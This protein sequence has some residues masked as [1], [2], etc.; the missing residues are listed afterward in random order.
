MNRQG[1]RL[2]E[3]EALR[4]IPFNRR[5]LSLKQRYI[6]D[7]PP[8]RVATV[9]PNPLLT[10]NDATVTG[11]Y[12][13]R[14]YVLDPSPSSLDHAFYLRNTTGSSSLPMY[15][16]SHRLQSLP[17]AENEESREAA[18]ILQNHRWFSILFGGVLSFAG[19]MCLGEWETQR[20]RKQKEMELQK[21][22]L[23]GIGEDR[24]Y[25]MLTQSERSVVA[26]ATVTKP[27][28]LTNKRKKEKKSMAE[29]FRPF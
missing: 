17:I 26:A 29:W 28:C 11:S 12:L 14:S 6:L 19:L 1:F 3:R 2:F 7:P 20:T 5:Y 8:T 27:S 24:Q 15:A 25:V 16:L 9:H 23:E 21:K 22:L 18:E 13:T 10:S 4:I